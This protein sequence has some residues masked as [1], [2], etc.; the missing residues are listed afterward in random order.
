MRVYPYALGHYYAY[1]LTD[2]T[3]ATMLDYYTQASIGLD[4]FP[5]EVQNATCLLSQALHENLYDSRYF[6]TEQF[7]GDGSSEFWKISREQME[8]L[9]MLYDALYYTC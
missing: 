6:G 5:V 3:V 7:Y 2:A 9:G 4:D 1:L 8:N